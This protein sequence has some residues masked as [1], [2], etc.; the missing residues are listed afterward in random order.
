MENKHVA[1]AVIAGIVVILVSFYFIMI[2]PIFVAKPYIAKPDL[3]T[4]IEAENVN[5]LSNEL[6]AYMLHPDLSGSAPIFQVRISDT[7]DV[8]TVKVV[9]NLPSTEANQT[10]EP[11]MRMTMTSATF[12]ELYNATDFTAKVNALYDAG[13]I[14][15][16]LLKD[17]TTL[18]LKGYKGV[19]DTL[20][21]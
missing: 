19:Y 10:A 3:G 17:S 20:G 8:F 14:S 21:R 4:N 15:I 6:G 7:D 12:R 16:E 18:A 2:S 13:S 11:D 9:N 5:W 1:L